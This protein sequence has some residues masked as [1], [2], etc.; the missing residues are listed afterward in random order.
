MIE[1]RTGDLLLQKDLTHIAHQ[2]NLYHNFGAGLAAAIAAKFPSAPY[3]DRKTPLGDEGKLGT[4]SVGLGAGHPA[5]INLYTQRGMH[6]T[7][8][9]AM[10]RALMALE[11]NLRM[12]FRYNIHLKLG[13]PYRLGCGIADGDW[14]EVSEIIHH[15]FSGSPIEVVICARP[16]DL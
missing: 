8:Y 3:V 10:R 9:D 12:V 1:E 2:A 5:I 7:D 14:R 16:E 11:M 13:L 4:Y 6:A 15:V